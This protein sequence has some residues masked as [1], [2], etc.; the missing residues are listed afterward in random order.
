[1]ISYRRR[2]VSRQ[3]LLQ[4]DIFQ[5]MREKPA[6]LDQAICKQIPEMYPDGL[7]LYICPGASACLFAGSWRDL[8]RNV[9]G[10]SAFLSSPGCLDFPDSENKFSANAA[11]SLLDLRG[12]F[13]YRERR[14]FSITA[15]LSEN[16]YQ[17][18]KQRTEKTSE[19]L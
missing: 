2:H 7:Y 8:S 6:K 19:R 15:A 3:V 13:F 12:C 17:V 18:F 5:Q 14:F 10:R 4:H 1:M 16:V 11:K 9:R